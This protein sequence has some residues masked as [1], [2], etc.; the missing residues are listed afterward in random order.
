MQ[1]NQVG[2]IPW[3]QPARMLD[4]QQLAAS[5]GDRRQRLVWFQ[6]GV[7]QLFDFPREVSGPHRAT[8]EA[9][10]SPPRR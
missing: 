9:D 6:P 1:E 2:W 10:A 8:A 5:P 4:P 7:D 3:L